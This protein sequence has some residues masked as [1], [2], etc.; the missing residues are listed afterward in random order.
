MSVTTASVPK[1]LNC[2]DGLAHLQLTHLPCLIL[3]SS[4]LGSSACHR[5]HMAALFK[6]NFLVAMSAN[7][8]APQE[9]MEIWN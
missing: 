2:K 3:G 7:T 9:I 4:N 1:H 5:F 8:K 6:G